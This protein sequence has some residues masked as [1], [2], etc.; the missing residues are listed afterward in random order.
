MFDSATYRWIIFVSKE[1]LQ[2]AAGGVWVELPGLTNQN[3]G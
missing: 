2:Q 1:T 3:Y